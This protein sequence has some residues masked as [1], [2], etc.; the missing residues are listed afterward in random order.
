MTRQEGDPTTGQSGQNWFLVQ[1]KPRECDRA[2]Q[3]L[4]NQDY[5]TFLPMHSVKRRRR[6]RIYYQR[7]PLFPHY[8]FMR[9]PHE[10]NWAAIRSTRG[11]ARMVSFNGAPQPVADSIV[12]GLH[13]QVALLDGVE[14]E[15]LFRTGEKV[16]ITE[17][18]FRELEAIVQCTRGDERVVLLL[19]LMNR[20][21]RVELPMASV[22]A[23]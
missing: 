15:P 8:L 3:H 6:G 4:E 23:R 20:E 2:R 9:T 11:V 12:E 10:A 1:C 5:N 7:E 17:G 19:N 22:A 13:R 18:C 16:T 14:P 21:Q